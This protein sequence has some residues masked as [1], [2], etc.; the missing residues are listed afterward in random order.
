LERAKRGKKRDVKLYP[1]AGGSANA[2]VSVIFEGILMTMPLLHAV[3]MLNLLADVADSVEL[4]VEAGADVQSVRIAI[5]QLCS[6]LQ[7]AATA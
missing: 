6:Q 2:S 3:V 4:L 5:A 7:L 1:D